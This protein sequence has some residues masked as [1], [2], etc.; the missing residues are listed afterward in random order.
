VVCG[1][2]RRYVA[3]CGGYV[4]MAMGLCGYVLLCY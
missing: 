3:V 4:A 2:G 1:R